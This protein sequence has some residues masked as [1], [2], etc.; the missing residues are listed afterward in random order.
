MTRIVL[1]QQVDALALLKDLVELAK[2]PK[3]VSEAHETAR[4]EFALTEK[5]KD[6]AEEARN[7]IKQ[8]QA[9][10]L[11]L[12]GQKASLELAHKNN[13]AELSNLNKRKEDLSKMV[14]ELNDREENVRKKEK[15]VTDLINELTQQK[16]NLNQ[17]SEKNN[18]DRF[19]L[20]QME[21]AVNIR[22]EKVKLR[23]Q[24]ANL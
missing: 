18:A 23:E 21:N 14:I 20:D 2:N 10:S 8:N 5:E 9:L 13:E 7:L 1:A 24:A 17:Q 15:E 22:L 11:E 3:L 12:D 16:Q 6:Q 19:K 4:N